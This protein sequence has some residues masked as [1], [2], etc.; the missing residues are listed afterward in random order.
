MAKRIIYW[1]RNDLRLE[2]NEAFN[3]AYQDSEEVVPVYVFDLR[4]FEQTRLGFRRTGALRAQIIINAVGALRESLRK[5]GGDLLIRIGEPE[6]VIAELAEECQADYVYASKKIGPKETYIESSLSKNL[7]VANIDFK[8]IWMDTLLNVVSLPFPIAKL[9]ANFQAYYDTIRHIKITKTN[10]VDIPSLSLQGE[11]EAGPLPNLP[12]IGMDPNEIQG[13]EYA[14][15]SNF[16]EEAAQNELESIITNLISGSY[17]SSG[18]NLVDS[19]LSTWLALGCISPRQ[20]YF[21]LLELPDAIAEK[22]LTIDSLHYRDYAHF[23]LLRFGPRFFKPGGIQHRFQKRWQNDVATFKLWTDANT[24]SEE[25]NSIIEKLK[26]TGHIKLEERYLAAHYLVDDLDINWVW[27]AM[28][29]ES[30]LLDYDVA[31]SWGR[32]NG[33][34]QVGFD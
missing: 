8:L 18:D 17:I 13:T 7:K 5:K 1:F 2:G 34:A 30:L 25:I 23:N 29:F 6:K 24:A 4:Q 3:Q 11:Y 28:Y 19:N 33:V 15:L 10:L 32:W 12:A 20:V 26:K 31:I 22:Q 21:K 16:G 14:T 27:G 9:P